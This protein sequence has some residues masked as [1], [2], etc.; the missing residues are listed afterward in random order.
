MMLISK[1]MPKATRVEM[2]LKHFLCTM[3][4]PDSSYSCLEIHICWKV[5]REARME[6][7]I[8]TEYFLSG[9]AMILIFMVEG[10]Q[11][12]DLL[13][14]SVGDTGVHGGAS[15]EDSVG[16]QVLPDV[17]IALH[18]GV[19]GGLVDAAGLHSQEAGL[20]EGLRAPEPLVADGDDLAVGKLVGLLQGAGGGSSGHLL[21]KVKSDIAQLLLDVPHDLPLGSG[22]ERVTP[23][24]QD[25]HEVVGE[26]TTGKV[27][28]EDGVGKGISLIDG[29]CVGDTVAGVKHNTGGTARGV[30]GKH[31]LDSDVHGGGIEG[32]EHDLGH[33][34]P[35][36]L[37]VE[38]GFGKEDWV[39]LG[40]NSQLIVE[41]VMPDLLHVIPVSHDTVL[42]WVLQGEDTLSW[43]GPRHRRRS[44]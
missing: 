13:L 32:L 27:E 26:V 42:N 15:R 21:L 16:I 35:V 23:L 14:H 41:G 43:T 1:H 44:P 22:G 24:G 20:E 11:G 18:D 36:G 38:G 31:S 12:S 6:P 40:G 17:N 25:L 7:P 19:V 29:D 5:E 3:D 37:G 39:L 2:H 4:G 10:G 34:L 33:L 30:Q 8:Q 9:G 28:P